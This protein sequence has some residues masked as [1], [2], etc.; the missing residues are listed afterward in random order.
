MG[1]KTTLPVFE[2]RGFVMK[3][4]STFII[5]CAKHWEADT[6]L[7]QLLTTAARAYGSLLEVGHLASF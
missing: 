6:C 7:K 4:A 3:Q 1:A 5:T 2:K